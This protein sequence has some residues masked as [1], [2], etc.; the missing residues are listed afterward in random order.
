MLTS[1]AQTNMVNLFFKVRNAY[2]HSVDQHAHGFLVDIVQAQLKGSD[3]CAGL[4]LAAGGQQQGVGAQAQL[5][6]L[7]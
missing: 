5:L 4:Q 1:A 3:H 2:L 7:A 6:F